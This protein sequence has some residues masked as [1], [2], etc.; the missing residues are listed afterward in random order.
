MLIQKYSFLQK[1][2]M[3]LYSSSLLIM[4]KIR[5]HNRQCEHTESLVIPF[6]MSD[7][8][9][10]SIFFPF[11][12]FWPHYVACGP[13]S[14]WTRGGKPMAPAVEMCRI[15]LWTTGSPPLS[16][17]K[18]KKEVLCSLE[19]KFFLDSSTYVLGQQGLSNFFWLTDSK[20]H[21]SHH[22]LVYR[23]THI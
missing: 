19:Q 6:Q 2:S 15:N 14:S 11:F 21:I 17:N 16:E 9:P 23:Y 20:I 1:W 4:G 3:W 18:N 10:L 8:G 13:L 7:S 12:L 22:N 5:P